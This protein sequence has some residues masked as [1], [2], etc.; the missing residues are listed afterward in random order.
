[1]TPRPSSKES[2]EVRTHRAQAE[3]EFVVAMIDA[4][5][6]NKPMAMAEVAAWFK[7]EWILDPFYR[8]ITQALFNVASAGQPFTVLTIAQ[9][10]TGKCKRFNQSLLEI[11]KLINE[12]FG[13]AHLRFLGRQLYDEY[14][15]Y[16]VANE[17]TGR[18][19]GLFKG[20][21]VEAAIEDFGTMPE[22]YASLAK[23]VK[24]NED[25]IQEIISDLDGKSCSE[26]RAMTGIPDLDKMTGGFGPGHLVVVGASTSNGKSS[27]LAHIA[28][29][30]ALRHRKRVCFF[31]VEMT[32]KEVY[33]RCASW[34]SRV[35][36]TDPDHRRDYIGGVG[37]VND[38]VTRQ[39]LLQVFSGG[40]TIHQIEKEVRAYKD[41]L[42][43]V[44]VDYIQLVRAGG[45]GDNRERQVAEVTSRLK[46]L[47]VECKV[48]ILAAS[49]LN[50]QA[51]EAPRMS[52]LRES[53]AIEQD[54]DVVMLL[55]PPASGDL[56]VKIAI[57]VAKNRHGACGN[58]PAMWFRP[59]YRYTEFS[60]HDS[61]PSPTATSTDGEFV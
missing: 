35:T 6:K 18:S 24:S 48:P 7:P 12:A 55:C 40:R 37:Q 52:N 59:I 58:V 23:R 39:G 3:R 21:E 46:I 49:Q 56:K 30:T 29:E 31:A 44:C 10:V 47:A 50:R 15:R 57:I 17:A 8:E 36:P 27:L 9:A 13:S 28:M 53:G 26:C 4:G 22:R 11:G 34:L 20:D 2:P 45:P 16:A 42:G 43:L 19:E 33:K 32:E 14:R 61:A 60:E 38:M 51:N 5:I 1:M 41:N 54:A 25:A